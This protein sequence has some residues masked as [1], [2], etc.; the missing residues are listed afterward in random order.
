MAGWALA[1]GAT[2]EQA[3]F[4]QGVEPAGQDVRRDAETLLELVEAREAAECVAQ[5]QDAPPFADAL[6]AAGDRASHVS[7]AF[8]LHGLGPGLVASCKSLRTVT[9]KMQV[10]K[11]RE[12]PRRLPGGG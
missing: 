1:V 8:A 5:D 3:A 7:E 6:Q 4:D 12:F 2:L 9:S 11:S 10:T